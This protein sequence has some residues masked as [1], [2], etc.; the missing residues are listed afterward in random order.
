MNTEYRKIYNKN[1]VI[2]SNCNIPDYKECYRS[3]MLKSNKLDNFLIYDTQSINGNVQFTYDISSKQSVYN[4]Y[5]N[6]LIDYETIRH[7]IMSLKQAF[8][9]LNNYLLEPDYIIL[10]PKLIYMNI[11]T[12]TIYF[13]YCPGHKNN[14]YGS[15]GE[16]LCYILS[17]IDHNDN[18]SI[19]LAYSLQQQSIQDN[20]TFDDLMQI[21]N[22]P[23]FEHEK[24][25]PKESN[26]NQ[27]SAPWESTISDSLYQEP[28]SN[29][30]PF[31]S[32]DLT[33]T[34]VSQKN[35]SATMPNNFVPSVLVFI[36]TFILGYCSLVLKLFSP[37]IFGILAILCM[38]IIIW[39]F[40]RKNNP[41]PRS[42]ADSLHL[43][44]N[45]THL[46]DLLNEP[47][48]S[49]SPL[50]YNTPYSDSDLQTESAIC[51]DTVILGYRKTANTPQL[52]Y[53]GTDFTSET[54]IDC[55][56]FVIGKMSGNVNMIIDNP[57]ISRI[58]ARIFFKENRFYI[59]DMNSS[60]G[61]Y[62][63]DT[64]IQPH[65]LTEI[66]IG[67]SIT[68]AHLTYIFQ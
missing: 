46:S 40:K 42:V 50:A 43:S 16:F 47:D 64:L 5:E 24:I 55:F 36:C 31:D 27:E 25:S 15:L 65:T 9:T 13:C 4:F 53:T 56:P 66:T 49:P 11:A 3:K 48:V 29:D 61:T 41:T 38:G 62:I 68:F 14:F 8:D 33:N 17:K 45:M 37:V 2:L 23:I 32:L 67:D 51:E 28:I 60:N 12:K 10:D 26:I 30:N 59:E 1:Y 63:N 6:S 34:T 19:I 18:N 20:Y 54:D 35:T 39:I 21:L 22:K 7:L 44:E 57:M 52:I 58:H